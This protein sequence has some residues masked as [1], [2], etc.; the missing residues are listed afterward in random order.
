MLLSQ[1]LFKVSI[2]RLLPHIREDAHATR[3]ILELYCQ[4]RS[5]TFHAKQP[6]NAAITFYN[7]YFLAVLNKLNAPH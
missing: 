1:Q 5:G 6:A 4:W 2:N 3:Q 7:F